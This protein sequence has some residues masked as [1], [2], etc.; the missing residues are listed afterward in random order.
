MRQN[1]GTVRWGMKHIASRHV[2]QSVMAACLGLAASVGAMAQP[3]DMNRFDSWLYFRRFTDGSGAWQIQP[4]LFVPTALSGGWTFTQR[5]DLPASYTDETGT[6]NPTGTWKAG[7]GDWF[8]EEIITTPE[9]AR[10]V[11]AWASMR[12][13]FPTGGASPFGSDQYQW[14]PALGVSYALPE[15]GL[16]FNPLVRYFMSYHATAADASKI[17]KLTLFPSVSFALPDNWSLAF[18]PENPI[19]YNSTSRKWFVPIDLML[20]KRLTKAVELGLGGA[21]AVVDDDP[22]YRSIVYG[23]LTFYF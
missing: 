11:R 1:L 23:R 12:F 10:N 3:L 15:R 17:R 4:R 8:V 16:T 18:Y 20:I 19:S 7:I 5:I 14:A 21:Y 2:H 22:L 9:L 6:N 13:V